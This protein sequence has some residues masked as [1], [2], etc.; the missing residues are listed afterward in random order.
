[1]KTDGNEHAEVAAEAG[2]TGS[3][4]AEPALNLLTERII[5][6]AIEVHR[7]LGAGLLESIYEECLCY[8]L[9]QSGLRFQ[10]Q[11]HL[12]IRYKG[13]QLDSAYTVDLV[14]EDSVVAE[15]KATEGTAPVHCAQLL[16]Y[17]RASSKEVGL[18]INFNVPVL[19]DGLKRIVNRYK[20]AALGAKTPTPGKPITSYPGSSP[21]LRVSASKDS[22]VLREAS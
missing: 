3:P 9:S 17:L 6:A 14:I 18:L 8:E 7:H 22:P 13:M 2:V 15:I 20:G 19:K 10:R 11:L 12:P 1:M 4:G 21:R 16:T 5:G